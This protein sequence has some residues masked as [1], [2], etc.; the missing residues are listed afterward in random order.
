MLNF[1][2]HH[3]L[4]FK[5]SVA[6][7]LIVLGSSAALG[8]F[9]LELTRQG[10]RKLVR[11]QFQATM[12]IVENFIDFMG[13]STL[14]LARHT[15]NETILV[16][17][18]RSPETNNLNTL[19]RKHAESI[20]AD[21]IMVLDARGRIIA[22]T[23][24]ET[25]IGQ[26]LMSWRIVRQGLER[27]EP[28]TSIAQEANWFFVYSSA[29]VQGADPDEAPLGLV[30][31]G[32]ALN[33]SF[34]GNIKENTEVD[35]T[36][37]RDRAVMVSTMSTLKSLDPNLPIP[38]PAYRG[39]LNRR[40][41]IREW[42]IGDTEYFIGARHLD[43]ME[44]GMSGSLLLAYPR[45]KLAAT[46]RHIGRQLS[47]LFAV[48]FLLVLIIGLRLSNTLVHRMQY[49]NGMTRRIAGGGLE[50][51]IAINSN[52]EFHD[53][54]LNFN[55]MRNAIREKNQALKD[56]SDNLEQKVLARTKA[57]KEANTHLE[58]SQANLSEA[59]HIAGVGSWELMRRDGQLEYSDEFSRI[60]A[61]PTHASSLTH[62][63][64]INRVHP[65]DR[66]EIHALW[67]RLLNSPRPYKM[68]Y[69]LQLPDSTI[70]HLHESAVLVVD[71]EGDPVRIHG[72]VQDI[73]ERKRLEEKIH[74]QATYDELTGLPNRI[75][76]HD[77]L[78]RALAR[79]ERKRYKIC[80]MYMDLD[81]FKQVN[82]TFGHNMGDRLLEQVGLRLLECIRE[83]DTAA[84]MGGDEFTA[85]LTELC[86][87]SDVER[88]G[89]KII[90]RISVPYRLAGQQIHIGV[91][92][93]VAMYPSDGDN[94]DILLKHADK[95]MYFAKGS[96]ENKPCFHEDIE[97]L[98]E[99]ASHH[100]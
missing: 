24:D 96:S 99:I 81:E 9:S 15:A 60:F 48:G 1:K 50:T 63:D 45:H 83:T 34:I 47:I 28:D 19:L 70:R 38:Y 32:H 85:I 37:V 57:L 68:D 61:A 14:I 42:R 59:Q 12:N 86:N 64:L 49:L 66:E 51:E 40:D 33:E 46:E 54:A 25:R 10:Y 27:R 73:T 74:R 31:M 26:S 58:K 89:K 2:F 41:S 22:A 72:T 75:L 82:D 65:D 11:E 4:R 18:L 35:I 30:L 52:D 21:N 91:S 44:P 20:S 17:A 69:R 36:I 13:Q 90:Q 6:F 77:R 98:A 29:V 67:G 5:I 7:L 78:R 100:A 84:R 62:E 97:D 55:Y 8:Y 53:L 79:A 80:V 87:R 3:R 76:F 23:L 39:L 16:S 92:I 88:I 43:A 71:T 94:L 56:Y 95:A 93:G